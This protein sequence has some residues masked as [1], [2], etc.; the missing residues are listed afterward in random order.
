MRIQKR[1]RTM[2]IISSWIKWWKLTM[3]LKKLNKKLHNKK[4]RVSNL[5]RKKQQNN[6]E[7]KIYQNNKVKE[8]DRC[9][10]SASSHQ[11]FWIHLSFKNNRAYLNLKE[12]KEPLA[13]LALKSFNKIASARLLKKCLKRNHFKI[14]NLQSL[15]KKNKV[16]NKLLKTSLKNHQKPNHQ[17]TFQNKSR[18]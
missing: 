15:K 17:L 16:K 12:A 6:L 9:R 8:L 18:L 11:W 3:I 4:K 1:L 2:L 7:R 10:L 5:S 13:L 14:I